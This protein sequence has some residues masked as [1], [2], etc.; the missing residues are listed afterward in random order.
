MSC[1]VCSV[2]YATMSLTVWQACVPEVPVLML[3]QMGSPADVEA[4]AIVLLTLQPK[5]GIRLH[6]APRAAT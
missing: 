5:N 3:M 4:S 1:V 6:C 2:R